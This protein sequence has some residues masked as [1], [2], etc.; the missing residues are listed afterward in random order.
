MQCGLTLTIDILRALP[1]TRR[2]GQMKGKGR[3][4]YQ[5]G[6]Q[7]HFD[8]HSPPTPHPRPLWAV[9]NKCL[10]LLAAPPFR[11]TP[12]PPRCSASAGWPAD[13]RSGRA[14]RLRGT[15]QRRDSGGAA[16]L[17]LILPLPPGLIENLNKQINHRS[18]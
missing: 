18:P 15:W 2:P 6:P 7:K 3:V 13:P 9:Q 5:R 1:L 16:L 12:P 11:R 14:V 17:P 10:R 4:I 8:L